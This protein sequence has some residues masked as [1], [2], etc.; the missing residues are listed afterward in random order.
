MLNVEIDETLAKKLSKYAT[1]SGQS[2]RDFVGTAISQ[3]IEDLEDVARVEAIIDRV[4]SG[5]EPLYSLEK[6]RK[7]LGL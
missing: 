3:H 4:E 1:E 7:D 6:V 2:I 5:K